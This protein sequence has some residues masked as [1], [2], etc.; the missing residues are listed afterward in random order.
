M[1][2]KPIPDGFHT[3]TP[4]VVVEGVPRLIEFLKT[5]FGAI[6]CIRIH[7]AEGRVMHAE[8]KIG[9][10]IVMMGEAMERRPCI[11]ALLHLYVPDTDATYR[12]ALDAGATSF[13][14]PG[15]QFWGDRM[16]GVQ[17]PAG[18]H[19]LIATHVEDVEPSEIARRALAFKKE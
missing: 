14:A 8:V 13:M 19:W 1:T 16:A 7:D 17:D 12:A 4:F 2:V 3:V 11:P 15:D 9:D 5:A 18:N 10:S 6:E